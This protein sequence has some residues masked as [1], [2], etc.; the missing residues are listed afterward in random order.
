[1]APRGRTRARDARDFRDAPR[2]RNERVCCIHDS[3]HAHAGATVGRS[4][5]RTGTGTTRPARDGAGRETAVGRAMDAMDAVMMM[6]RR[7]SEY[8]TRL[9]AIDRRSP[10]A[11]RRSIARRRSAGTRTTDA[12]VADRRAASVCDAV[13]DGER[14]RGEGRWCAGRERARRRRRRRRRRGAG[15]P[16]SSPSSSSS[17]SPRPTSTWGRAS[18]RPGERWETAARW[19]GGFGARDDDDDDA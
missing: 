7:M 9:T 2:R 10:I 11:D 15:E 5:P 12:P 14:W 16:S 4:R 6:I 18:S 3:T 17:A 13:R 19:D 8:T 1:M